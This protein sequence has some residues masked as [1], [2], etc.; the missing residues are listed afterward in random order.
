M[1]RTSR[2]Q[3]G[4][5]PPAV[6]GPRRAATRRLRRGFRGVNRSAR[7]WGPVS[8]CLK[9]LCVTPVIAVAITFA[10]TGTAP[11]ARRS[12]A[13]RAP[14]GSWA[15]A[16]PTRSTPKRGSDVVRAPRRQRHHYARRRVDRGG[17][18]GGDDSVDGGAGPDAVDAGPG[19]DSVTGGP[20][21]DR[22]WAG[23]G[24]RHRRHGSRL[25]SRARP[26]RRRQD[27]RR[28]RA[29]T[30]CTAA[31][32]RHDQRRHRATIASPRACATGRRDTVNGEAGDDRI[33][34]RDGTRDVVT[35][36]P[37]SIA[38]VPTSHDVVAADCEQVKRHTPN[39]R[40]GPDV[41]VTGAD[42]G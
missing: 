19:N 8:H 24:E 11:R 5:R 15:A 4:P 23:A 2:V 34:V 27:Q 40:R 35:C 39:P 6:S 32:G 42:D 31:S 25:R 13:P 22:V 1:A 33:Q 29:S 12:P 10:A 9:R 37:G 7:R 41:G 21:D 26:P 17:P 16:A 36:G 3:L 28:R 14:T 30:C 20:G 18:A 38:S